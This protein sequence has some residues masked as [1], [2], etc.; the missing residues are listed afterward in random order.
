MK[1][2]KKSEW[3]RLDNAAKIFPPTS[4]DKDTKVFRFTIELYEKI[5]PVILQEAVGLTMESFP[6]YKV[7]L[8]RGAFWY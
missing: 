8:R 7:V 4:S 5:D 6:F 3:K 2:S 1:Q